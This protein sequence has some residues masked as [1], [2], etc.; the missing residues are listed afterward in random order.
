MVRIAWGE[1]LIVSKKEN[2][3]NPHGFC[4]GAPRTDH[5]MNSPQFFALFVVLSGVFL[6]YSWCQP[7]VQGKEIF[8]SLIRPLDESTPSLEKAHELVKTVF[9]EISG[10]LGQPPTVVVT[11]SG[12]GLIWGD[13]FKTGGCFALAELTPQ[14][15]LE[16]VVIGAAFLEW[17]DEEWR[18]RQVWDIPVTWRPKGWQDS[19][20]DYLP[21]TPATQPF[22]LEDFSGDG[23]PEAVIAGGVEK[24]FQENYM[25]RFIPETENLKIVAYAMARPVTIG[26]YVRLYSD[27]GRRAIWSQWDYCKW[28][29]ADLIHVA[30]W[31][32]ETGYDQNDPTFIEGMRVDPD[33]QPVTIRVFYGHGQEIEN[34]SYELTRNGI[35]FG[36]M[37]IHWKNPE[38]LPANSFEMEAMWLFEK[39]TGLPP[40]LY[41]EAETT[42]FNF[43]DFATITIEG[44]KEAAILFGTPEAVAP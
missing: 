31:H 32:S 7:T 14:S 41:P 29:G 39:I 1:K 37:R 42:D 9:S 24:Y 2:R 25:L 19:G 35:P 4:H 12:V 22:T 28:E 26:N 16:R 17:E 43:K 18:L 30:S 27:S 10:K 6:P 5:L 40:S 44:N 3:N 33:G 15:D 36:K 11:K 23:V 34:E 13:L 21:A 8:D 38:H 20:S